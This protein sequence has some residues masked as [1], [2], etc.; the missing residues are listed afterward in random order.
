MKKIHGLI[1]ID[2][3]VIMIPFLQTEDPTIVKWAGIVF[4]TL[5]TLSIIVI[6]VTDK[7]DSKIV[8]MIEEHSNR[9]GW[10]NTYDAVSDLVIITSWAL[11]GNYL[12]GILLILMKA[13]MVMRIPE[14]YNIGENNE[15]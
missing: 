14:Y 3:L 13:V 8:E 15:K 2:L 4:A 9:P 7:T 1:A 10:W 5:T 6:M 11:I 12:I